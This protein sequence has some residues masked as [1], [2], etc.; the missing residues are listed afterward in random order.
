MSAPRFIHRFMRTTTTMRPTTTFTRPF[1]ITTA[2]PEKDPKDNDPSHAAR[3]PSF[4]PEHRDIQSS[5]T[6]QSI[7][8]TTSTMTSDYPKVGERTSPP[9]MLNSVNPN[10][11]PADPYPGRVE[12]FTGGGQESGAQKPELG[13]GEMEG[14]RF[15]VEPLKR[16]GEDVTTLR[17][18]LLCKLPFPLPYTSYRCYRL[19]PGVQNIYPGK[20]GS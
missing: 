18:R 5:R 20:H 11:R 9:E 1:S 4:A 17:A 10:Y 2:R 12:H 15:R 8:N 19:I 3:A 6:N 14:I 7:P 13:V 16:K